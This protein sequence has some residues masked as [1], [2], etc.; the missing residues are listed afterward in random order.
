MGQR[1]NKYSPHIRCKKQFLVKSDAHSTKIEAENGQPYDLQFVTF[2]RHM[3]SMGKEVNQTK[4]NLQEMIMPCAQWVDND[5]S[6]FIITNEQEFSR[7][8]YLFKVINSVYTYLL[9]HVL[10]C[11]RVFV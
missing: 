1:S 7:R 3:L 10:F 11:S 5:Q 9:I 4:N 6:I 8:W 2:L